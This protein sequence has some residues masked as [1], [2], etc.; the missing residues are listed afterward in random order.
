VS[1]MS[2]VKCEVAVINLCS[3]SDSDEPPAKRHHAAAAAPRAGSAADM[4]L[5]FEDEVAL[6][7]SDA[8]PSN[9]ADIHSVSSWR[10][11]RSLTYLFLVKTPETR[12]A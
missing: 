3:D 6:C 4:D 2:S 8:I 9:S 11:R 10:P 12:K 7:Q 1:P 5:E